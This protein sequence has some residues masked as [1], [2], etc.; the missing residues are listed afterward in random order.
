MSSIS[1]GSP[2]ALFRHRSADPFTSCSLIDLIQREDWRLAVMAVGP[3]EA[4]E[5]SRVEGFFDGQHAS[6]VLPIHQ[7]CALEPPLSIIESLYNANPTGFV[8]KEKTF[9][10]LPLHVACQTKASFEV[11]EKLLEFNIEAAR[12]KDALGRLPIH[13]ACAHGAPSS[14]VDILLQAFPASTHCGDKNGWVPLHVACRRGEDEST[15]R[16]LLEACP[17]SLFFETKKGSTPLMCAEKVADFK[18]QILARLLR[19]YY[20]KADPRNVDK[21]PDRTTRQHQ[22]LRS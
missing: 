13:Y 10:R 17:S 12:T 22:V 16:L 7:A 15:I 2:F 14:V 9:L 19:D 4:A 6:S 1:I 18:H 5:W 8:K 21:Y 3:K 11:V 20:L